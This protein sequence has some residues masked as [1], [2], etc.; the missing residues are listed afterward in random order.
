ASAGSSYRRSSVVSFRL[1]LSNPTLPEITDG[2][3]TQLHHSLGHDQVFSENPADVHADYVR[4]RWH[5]GCRNATQLYREVCNQGYSESVKTFR[6]WVKVRL[7]DATP[8]P[9]L[10]RASHKSSWH[11]PTSRQMVRLLTAEIDTL[12]AN[13]RAFVNAVS[14]ASPDV[15][16]AAGLARRFQSM[17]CNREAAAPEPWLHDA[18]TGPMSSFSRGIRRDVEAVR[19]A[20]T[21]QW[22][23]GPVEGKINKLK[24]IKRSMYGRVGID[25]LR[26]RISGT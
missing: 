14:S 2:Y 26:S 17:I 10:S 18:T 15:A 4:R 3:E 13:D 22:S 24:L 23:T 16:N 7:R 11:M 9:A 20:L 12:P 8:A 21:V 1:A 25:L 5:E 19:A 6:L